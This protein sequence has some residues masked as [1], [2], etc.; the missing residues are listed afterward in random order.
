MRGTG[1]GGAR[2]AKRRN[3]IEF[4]SEMKFRLEYRLSHF[5]NIRHKITSLF[6]LSIVVHSRRE[7]RERE[8]KALNIVKARLAI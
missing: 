1:R 7:E 8:K 5:G 4:N 2:N 6:S 3:K